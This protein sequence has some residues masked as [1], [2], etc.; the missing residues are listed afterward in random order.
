MLVTVGNVGTVIQMSEDSFYFLSADF[1]I[2]EK[3]LIEPLLKG[4]Q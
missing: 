4:R 2:F 3:L 1:Y